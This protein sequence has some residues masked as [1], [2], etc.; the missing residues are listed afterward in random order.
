MPF[1]EYICEKC[2]H[3]FEIFQKITAKPVGT[4]EKCKSKKVSR[5][6]FA[7]A[8]H[9]KGD[10]FYITDYR[11]KGYLDA[12]K[13]EKKTEKKSDDAVNGTTEKKMEKKE[14]GEKGRE[15][16]T[17]SPEEAKSQKKNKKKKEAA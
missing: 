17:K 9:F 5:K 2:E 13:A 11:D 6:I 12:V 7:P 4:C 14:N 3:E 16:G 1:Y 10:G 15:P 8:V